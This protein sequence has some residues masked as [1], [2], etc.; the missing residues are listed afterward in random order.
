[1]STSEQRICPDC[2]S[3]QTV[4]VQR[5]LAGP[6][7]ESDQYFRCLHCGRVTY[8]IVSRTER[9]IRA[10]RITPGRSLR[11]RGCLYTVRR[12]LKVGMNE[13]LVY[14]RPEQEPG[15][16]REPSIPTR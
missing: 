11:E 7:D 5:G 3:S 12:V 2:G 9:E 8:E 15:R 13:Y 14:L 4:L 10:A 1:M 16:D 6:T